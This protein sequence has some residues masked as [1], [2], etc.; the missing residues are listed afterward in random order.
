MH[1]RCGCVCAC[2]CV[3]KRVCFQAR[4][5]GW[6]LR[7]P[8]GPVLALAFELI[9]AQR[10][11]VETPSMRHMCISSVCVCARACLHYVWMRVWRVFDRMSG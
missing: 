9:V 8:D 2:V 5:R 11:W 4:L 3:C 6:Y 10:R 1:Q 7:M